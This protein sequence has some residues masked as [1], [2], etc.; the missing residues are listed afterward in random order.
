MAYM[1]S[2]CLQANMTIYN[3]ADNMNSRL[4]AVRSLIL[5]TTHHHPTPSEMRS[6]F[7]DL[8]GHRYSDSVHSM[9][10]CEFHS[11]CSRLQ[12][13]HGVCF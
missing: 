1:L 11:V 10:N 3:E 8:E 9:G 13:G 7:R 2:Y 12:S 5:F 6:Q 4:S